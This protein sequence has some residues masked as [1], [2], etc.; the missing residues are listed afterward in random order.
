[1]LYTLDRHQLAANVPIKRTKD[2]PAKLENTK[3]HAFDSVTVADAIGTAS[4]SW[5]S[6]TGPYVW[7]EVQYPSSPSDR[8]AFMKRVQRSLHKEQPV[9]LQWYVDFNALDDQAWFLKPPATPGL[10]RPHAYPRHDEANERPG[11]GTLRRE[12]SR[13]GRR[14]CKQCSPTDHGDGLANQELVAGL[15]LRTDHFGYHDSH[16]DY[17]NGPLEECATDAAEHPIL[18]QCHDET[19]LQAVVLPAG[20]SSRVPRSAGSRAVTCAKGSS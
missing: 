8:R 13:R 12:R 16:L 1:M 6:R 17:L 15:P 5:D 11:F 2:F 7:S 18:T 20:Y 14:R 3:T 19:P 9:I 10:G 4:F